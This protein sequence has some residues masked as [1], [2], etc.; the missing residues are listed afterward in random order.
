MK[1]DN[2]NND[3]YIIDFQGQILYFLKCYSYIEIEKIF[4]YNEKS[5]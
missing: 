2:R 5:L 1:I 3:K 4:I